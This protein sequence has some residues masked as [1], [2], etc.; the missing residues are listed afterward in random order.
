[1]IITFFLYLFDI[2]L[3]IILFI[4]FT[5]LIFYFLFWS[6]LNRTN[7]KLIEMSNKFF[8]NFLLIIWLLFYKLK[9]TIIAAWVFILKFKIIKL[10]LVCRFKFC[11]REISIFITLL[12]ERQVF[13][14]LL[15]LIFIF[16]N[17][18]Y[19]DWFLHV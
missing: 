10:Q 7:K 6:F 8:I 19:L 16:I 13:V 17:L 1:M 18:N 11:F 14:Y 2:M 4:T 12:N 9:H 5:N 3:N 15:Y